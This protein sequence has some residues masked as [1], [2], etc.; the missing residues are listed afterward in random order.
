MF[1]LYIIC[2]WRFKSMTF[3]I[4]GHL[5]IY[6]QMSGHHHRLNPKSSLADPPHPT[7]TQPFWPLLCLL[8]LSRVSCEHSCYVFVWPEPVMLGVG[9]LWCLFLPL[10]SGGS[11]GVLGG[12]YATSRD[13]NSAPQAAELE[14]SPTGL[15]LQCPLVGIL[16]LEND[17]L[18]T[19]PVL[20]LPLFSVHNL[21]LCG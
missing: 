6:S 20:P 18:T 21:W 5:N 3:P 9:G 1:L 8:A 7:R 11:P 14:P 16:Y 15:S 2:Q 17:N 4:Q 19:H 13:L 10:C 12:L